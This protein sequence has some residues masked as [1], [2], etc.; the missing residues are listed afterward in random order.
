MHRFDFTFNEDGDYVIAIQLIDG[1]WR[2]TARW[3]IPGT[4]VN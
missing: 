2:E 1:E 3:M 4:W